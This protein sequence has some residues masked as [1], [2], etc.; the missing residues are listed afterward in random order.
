MK[1][2]RRATLAMLGITALTVVGMG[3]AWAT[4]VTWT[5]DAEAHFEN[6]TFTNNSGCTTAAAH[7]IAWGED[8]DTQSSLEIDPYSTTGKTVDTNGPTS[9]PGIILTHNNFTIPGGSPVLDTTT[10]VASI[11]LTAPPGAPAIDPLSLM[12]QFDETTNNPNSGSCVVGS[13]PCP[14]IFVISGA[15]LNQSFTFDGETYFLSLFPATDAGNLAVLPDE[16]CA[17]VGA[18]P[19]CLGFITLEGQSNDMLFGVKITTAP[20]GTP[21]PGILG[22]MGLG[23]LGIAGL[24]I[25]RR[26]LG[27]THD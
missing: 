16:A 4:V 14:D 8:C 15:F 19:G 2:V 22:M 11:T 24:A 17:D 9:D 26:K 5:Y 6:T 18:A 21:E 23:L 27:V 25:R 7:N 10:L 13:P 12:I 1:G 20:I 3:S